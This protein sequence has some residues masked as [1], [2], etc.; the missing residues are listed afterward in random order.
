[1][2][3]HFVIKKYSKL[4]EIILK[5]WK[6]AKLLTYLIFLKKM[7][8]K[9]D[10]YIIYYTVYYIH[11][12]FYQ[13]QNFGFKWIFLRVKCIILFSIFMKIIFIKIL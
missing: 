3:Y 12:N 4:Y 2:L 7:D 10:L 6:N 8:N 9:I 11:I 1:M 5:I 13:N